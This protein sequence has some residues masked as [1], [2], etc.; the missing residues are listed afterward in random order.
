[1]QL[2]HDA[3]LEIPLLRGSKISVS[4]RGDGATEDSHRSNTPEPAGL[5]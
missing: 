5:S 2:K 3:G 4:P 1:M